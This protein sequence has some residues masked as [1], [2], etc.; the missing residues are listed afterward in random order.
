MRRLPILLAAALLVPHL[1]HAGRGGGANQ[2]LQVISPA[3][4]GSAPAH[5]FVNVIVS[6]GSAKGVDPDPSTFRARLGRV[7]VTPLFRQITS[8]G[9]VVRLHGEIAPALLRVGR[10]RSNRLRFE[11]LSAPRRRGRLRDIDQFRFR[12]VDAPNQA[13]TA[14]ANPESDVILPGIPVAFDA[15]ASTD[16]ESDFLE[17]LWDFGN[18]ATSTDA[19]AVYSFPPT[20]G[21]VTVRLT[22]SD[23]QST[24]VVEQT[25]LEVPPLDPGR[26]PGAMRCESDTALEFGAV[27]PGTTATRT[28]TVRN[29]DPTETSQL[30]VRLG[31]AGAGYTL[32]RATLD[33]GPNE[34]A[35]VTVAFTATGSGHRPGQ[36][37]LVGSATNQKVVHMLTHAYAGA[38][39]G[40]G[41]LPTVEPVFYNTLG[42]GT[43]GI[44]PNGKRF[45]A[46]NTA[47][48]CQVAAG[49]LGIGD[50][51]L[52]DADCGGGN[53]CP[54]TGVCARG[55]RGGQPCSALGDCPGSFC[56]AAFPF[57]PADMCGDG[58]GGLYIMSDEG[59]YTDPNQERETLL[60]VSLLRLQFDASGQRIGAEIIA[61]TTEST[62][63]I[64]CDGTPAEAGGRLYVPEYHNVISPGDCFRDA[65]EALV[66][67]RK[68]SGDASVVMPRIDTIEN[69][70]DCDDVDTVTDLQAARDGSAV[71]ASLPGADIDTGGIYRIR[72]T[73]L[74]ILQDFDDIFQVHPDGSVIVATAS[75][76]GTNGIL[77]VYK[78]SPEQ[79]QLGAARLQAL[80]PCATF[81]VPNNRTP[82]RPRVTLLTYY[83]AGRASTSSA[84]GTILV[85]FST[86]AGPALSPNLRVQGTVAIASP[87]GSSTCSIVGLVNL[88]TLDQLTF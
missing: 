45:L 71:F 40:N 30:R 13:P 87:A 9:K 62:T 67:F 64:A 49:G 57:D 11:V 41:P 28:F 19:R 84:D 54:A 15:S 72:P 32:D 16:P 5:P 63:Q 3:V 14:H 75:D 1:A 56:T 78:I 69:L 29:T 35:P 73:T 31:V 68:S 47:H 59:A 60:M 8:N 33:L 85:N 76:E 42:R 25:L 2:L 24:A 39:E 53:T 4:R 81:A 21:D 58:Q 20:D 70:N 65:R 80:P 79:A 61:R 34:S 88:E 77:R 36:L 43:A 51:C 18:G 52:D 83:A 44:L 7:D 74:R 22:V 37:S 6:L 27:P 55:E 86:A 66:A 17:Y 48:A 46:D 12:A 38:G 23:G 26:T 82:E 10:G 50:F